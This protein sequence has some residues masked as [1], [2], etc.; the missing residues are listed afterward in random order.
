MNIIIYIFKMFCFAFRLSHVQ[1]QLDPSHRQ[2]DWPDLDRGL[3]GRRL[4]QTLL[5]LW[6]RKHLVKNENLYFILKTFQ[7]KKT[8]FENHIQIVTSHVFWDKNEIVGKFCLKFKILG[9]Y[10]EKPESEKKIKWL[11]FKC[12]ATFD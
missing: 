12:F 5:W 11:L 10:H 7:T 1:I 9:R 4:D 8:C 2:R 6:R 3:R